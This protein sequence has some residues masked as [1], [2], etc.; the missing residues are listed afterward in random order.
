MMP[1]WLKKLGNRSE[2]EK[3]VLPD[4]EPI[5]VVKLQSRVFELEQDSLSHTL[6]IQELKN[7]NELK[8]KKI[9]D[10]ET[11]MGHLS[12]IVLDLKQRLQDKF[13]GEFIDE[14]SPSDIVESVP[15][16]SKADFNKLIKSR[17]EG[18]RKYFAGETGF[19]VSMAKSREFMMIIERTVQE[20]RDAAKVKPTRF[21]ADMGDS[22][23]N[24]EGDRS[25]IVCWGYDEVNGL[26]WVRRNLTKRIEY[27]D[28]PSS[29][30]S[31]TVVDMVELAR[32]RF[33]NPT[34]SKRGESFYTLLQQHVRKGFS[35]MTLAKSVRMKKTTNSLGNPIDVEVFEVKRP[36]TDWMK[37]V[38]ILLDLPEGVLDNF[39]FWAFDEQT[40]GVII[41]CGEVEITFYDPIDLMRLSQKDIK[42]LNNQEVKVDQDHLEDALEFVV[43]V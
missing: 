43:Y 25:G 1:F 12:A 14:T 2:K 22:R 28:H 18:L 36:A 4:D 41:S 17:E 19:K 39:M 37:K 10:L 33:F 15:E 5:D 8:D 29:F 9:K 32:Q 27:Y 6:L 23:F 11:N 30:K 40:C 7:D 34:T 13:K 42:F 20:A 38:P 21:V 35:D 24:Y 31:L 26:W 16:L 3:N